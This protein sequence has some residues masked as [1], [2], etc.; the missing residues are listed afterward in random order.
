MGAGI[1]H[2]NAE[3]SGAAPARGVV[4]VPGPPRKPLARPR[5]IQQNSAS[6]RREH[7]VQR[8][9]RDLAVLAASRR[10]QTP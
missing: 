1:S 3:A 4:P 5:A 9:I 8:L 6:M 2:A 7:E 10:P